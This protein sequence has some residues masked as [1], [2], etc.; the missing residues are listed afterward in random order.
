MRGGHNFDDLTGRR[1]CRLLVLGRIDIPEETHCT[2]WRVRCDCGVEFSVARP[3][4]ISGQT[5]SC[6]CLR[7]ERMERNNPRRAAV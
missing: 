7:R 1:F 6:G 5:K 3:N 2:Y 4:L